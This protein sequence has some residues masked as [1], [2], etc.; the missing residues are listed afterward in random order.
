MINNTMKTM[1]LIMVS[2]SIVV[3]L[4]GCAKTNEN[5][6]ASSLDISEGVTGTEND[7]NEQSDA[8]LQGEYV[9]LNLSDTVYDL[10]ELEEAINLT[11]YLPYSGEE[12]EVLEE[13][14][15]AN[16]DIMAGTS[17][18]TNLSYW[19]RYDEPALYYDDDESNDGDGTEV[20]E[21]PEPVSAGDVETEDKN[22]YLYQTYNDGEYSAM[23]Y[24]GS[25]MFEMGDSKLWADLAGS[26]VFNIDYQPVYRP[27]FVEDATLVKEYFL[28]DDDIEGISYTLMDGEVSLE[29]AV[30]YMES[31]MKNYYFAKSDYLDF[32][33]YEIDVYQLTT[34]E[35]YYYC[36]M[37]GYVG[38]IPVS[39]DQGYSLVAD[40]LETELDIIGIRDH[41]AM[42]YSGKIS[43]FWSQCGYEDAE[44]ET[45][46][47]GDMI[48]VE[49]ACE[50]VSENLTDDNVFNV[51]TVSM[52]YYVG[53]HYSYDNPPNGSYWCDYRKIRL[54]YTFKINN[55]KV[56]GYS[57]VTFLVDAVTGE[58]ITYVS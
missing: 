6:N 28:P 44:V 42:I 50:I 24:S 46:D 8:S 52:E 32:R 55:P 36:F 49:E 51:T 58:F 29:D 38:D 15:L 23:L 53:C 19:Q 30:E 39:Y 33:V 13:K 45:V 31:E 48:T 34:G 7:T 2:L 14:I 11:Y 17:D 26:D 22:L 21:M 16:M 43:Y 40:D 47:A 5:E 57:S 12:Y 20:Y 10:P 25:F 54:Y 35:Y 41:V 37:Q 3:S 56:L 9:N 18:D 4:A 1:S 27:M